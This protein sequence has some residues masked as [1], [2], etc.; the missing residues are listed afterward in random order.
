MIQSVVVI[1]F[2][3]TEKSGIVEWSTKRFKVSFSPFCYFSHIIG[4]RADVFA[5]PSTFCFVVG[6]CAY[7]WKF[8]FCSLLF[9]YLI[10]SMIETKVVDLDSDYILYFVTIFLL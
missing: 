3:I 6:N 5:D 1:S 7:Q 8:I 4:F 2:K 9:I 10:E